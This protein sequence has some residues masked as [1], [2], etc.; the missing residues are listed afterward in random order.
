MSPCRLFSKL[1]LVLKKLA[2]NNRLL[3]SFSRPWEADSLLA[4]RSKSVSDLPTTVN[5]PYRHSI[6]LL[7]PVQTP[8]SVALHWTARRWNW[9]LRTVAS[10]FK[11]RLTW[12]Y[13]KYEYCNTFL[14]P[15]GFSVCICA[16]AFA[17]SDR[18]PRN[19]HVAPIFKSCVVWMGA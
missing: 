4:A 9:F 16:H 6:V 15:Q 13:C 19:P 1:C 7:L 17:D 5:H 10:G 8:Y 14:W 2:I 3:P 11:V 18:A 12:R